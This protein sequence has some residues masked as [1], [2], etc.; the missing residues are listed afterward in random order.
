LIEVDVNCEAERVQR[1]GDALQVERAPDAQTP[2]A[3]S[4]PGKVREL[5]P[6]RLSE[7]VNA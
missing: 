3:L 5:L 1:E 7:R 2:H 4:I 6:E